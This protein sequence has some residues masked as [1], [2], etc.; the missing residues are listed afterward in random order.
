MH[1]SCVG[2]FSALA[3]TRTSSSSFPTFV[4]LTYYLNIDSTA[5]HQEQKAENKHCRS[6]HCSSGS[7]TEDTHWS[8]S[9]STTVQ[10]T[11]IHL[12]LCSLR[13]LTWEMDLIACK[14]LRG[15]TSLPT[16]WSSGVNVFTDAVSLQSP[17]RLPVCGV[18]S[19]THLF[20]TFY[21]WNVF[22]PRLSQGTGFEKSQLWG[23]LSGTQQKW[24][25]TGPS[26]Q[27]RV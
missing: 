10:D 15:F 11:W 25:C 27:N 4:L 24:S 3:F 23:Y 2:N 21:Q 7:K 17:L 14:K 12:Q 18:L 20:L 16:D 8:W 6:W 22:K 9:P 5:Q 1:L 19:P 13:L 26:K